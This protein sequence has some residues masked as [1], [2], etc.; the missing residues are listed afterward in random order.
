MEIESERTDIK[1][2]SQIFPS[3]TRFP[4]GYSSK[5][6]QYDM[7]VMWKND[8]TFYFYTNTKRPFARIWEK[9]N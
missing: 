6:F 1:L 3:F 5:S 9:W 8:S 2:H 7:F 4:H